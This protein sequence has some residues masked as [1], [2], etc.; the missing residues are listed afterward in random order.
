MRKIEFCLEWKLKR[1]F[2]V[3]RAN[4]ME[5]RSQ[6]DAFEQ[7]NSKSIASLI[8]NP[9]VIAWEGKNKTFS[10]YSEILHSWHI[11]TSFMSDKWIDCGIFG[12]HFHFLHIHFS[13]SIIEL[14][15]TCRRIRMLNQRLRR[16]RLT[17]FCWGKKNVLNNC[18][19][20]ISVP[21]NFV[22][23]K[24]CKNRTFLIKVQKISDEEHFVANPSNTI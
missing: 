14:F 13:L 22:I 8:T 17:L 1:Y 21:L 16:R 3:L 23:W 15:F 20:L 10:I 18:S 11:T 19:R 9:K 2:E 5:N 4:Y 24:K 7:L 6:M 12:W